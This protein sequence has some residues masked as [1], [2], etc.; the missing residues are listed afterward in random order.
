MD[1]NNCLSG[2]IDTFFLTNIVSYKT[3]FKT[4]NGTLLDNFAFAYKET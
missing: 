1:K 3:C 2:F 4:L